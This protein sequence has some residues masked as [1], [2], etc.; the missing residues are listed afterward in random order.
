M[1][2]AVRTSVPPQSLL[3]AIRQKLHEL[4][5]DLPLANVRTMDEWL[6]NSAA[7][8]RLNTVLLS[9][10]A[11]IALLVAVMGVYGVLAYSVDQRTREIGLRIALG[12]TPTDVLHQIVGEGMRIVLVG[13]A[14]GVACGLALG[15]VL[16]GLVYGV[17]V[18]DPLIFASVVIILGAVAFAAC[19]I[20]ATRA[21][22]VQP[23]IALRYE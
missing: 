21:A 14:I 8:P 9:S 5:P 13:I 7:Q 19:S 23:M 2:V 20:P 16:S 17:R 18:Y 3:A 1:D 22:R 10:F 12:A 11:A 15:R 6:A 4:D